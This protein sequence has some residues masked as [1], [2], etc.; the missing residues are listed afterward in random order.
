MANITLPEGF[1]IKPSNPIALDTLEIHKLTQAQYDKLLS[2]NLINE[3]AIYMTPN[4]ALDKSQFATV[5]E[6]KKKADTGHKHVIDDVAELRE[7]LDGLG[8]NKADAVHAHADLYYTKDEVK[9][10]HEEMV[11]GIE[12]HINTLVAPLAHISGENGGEITD[13]TT[14]AAVNVQAL[15]NEALAQAKASGSFDGDDGEN[16]RDGKDGKDGEDG[17]DGVTPEKGVH[18]WTDTDKTEIISEVLAQ[19]PNGNEVAY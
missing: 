10:I 7:T 16:G 5:E 14:G 8:A 2:N 11:A 1:G 3:N 9:A 12:N 17:K 18:Y 4:E 13:S 15:I 19:I 6:L